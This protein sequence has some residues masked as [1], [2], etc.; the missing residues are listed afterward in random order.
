MKINIT[1]GKKTRPQKLVIYG[2]EGVGKTTLASQC[3][4]PLFADCEGGTDH[5]DLARVEVHN[6][7]EFRETCLYLIRDNSENFESF[8]VDTADWLAARDVEEMLGEDEKDSVEDYGYGK[9]YKKAEE[10]FHELLKLLDRVKKSGVHVILLAHSKVIK[11]EE[12]D[13]SG[14][15]DRYELKLEKKVAP[16]LKEWC[17]ALLFLNFETRIVERTKGQEGKKRGIGGTKRIL[18]CERDAAFDAKNR[19][20]MPKT[21]EATVEEL[22]P[23]LGFKGDEPQSAPK[24]EPN[25]DAEKAEQLGE[26]LDRRAEEAKPEPAEAAP[27]AEPDERGESINDA[28]ADLVNRSGGREAVAA[29]LETRNKDIDELDG[30]YVARVLENSGAFTKAVAEHSK[31]LAAAS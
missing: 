30:A 19:H 23:I 7:A 27:S 24:V 18:H 26:A 29:F 15:Y 9:G 4:K 22:K 20:G 11:F 10:R 1:R 13:K 3:P 31:K 8:I 2:P 14:S 28:F 21:C 25:N 17:D 16:L 5:I 12:P 6:I